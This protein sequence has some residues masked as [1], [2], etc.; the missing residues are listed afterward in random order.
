MTEVHTHST[1]A[2]GTVHVHTRRKTPR[3]S[4][5][6]GSAECLGNSGWKCGA[7]DFVA[8]TGHTTAVAAS[9]RGAHTPVLVDSRLTR[10]INLRYISMGTELSK[11]ERGENNLGSAEAA[12][13]T[14]QLIAAKWHAWLQDAESLC[15]QGRFRAYREVRA[16]CCAFFFSGGAIE[17]RPLQYSTTVRN[18]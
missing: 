11:Q 4:H 18:I 10:E 16:R 12:T 2:R 15:L 9:P 6:R 14:T 13:A 17:K 5:G 1:Q 8:D 7:I 3:Q